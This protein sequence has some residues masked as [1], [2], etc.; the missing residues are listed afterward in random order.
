MSWVD[1]LLLIFG[2][3]LLF[4]GCFR[5]VAA[6]RKDIKDSVLRRS[7]YPWYGILLPVWL[8]AATGITLHGSLETG[9]LSVWGVCGY[10]LA[11]TGLGVH[12]GRLIER[13][14]REGRR[15]PGKKGRTEP[16]PEGA[17]LSD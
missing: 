2:L 10:I 15:A 7:D 16:T 1:G 8:V 3:G 17:V 11:F 6:T 5:P 13:G 9:T 4:W 14:A 12:T